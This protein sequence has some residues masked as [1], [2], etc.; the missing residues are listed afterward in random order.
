MTEIIRTYICNKKFTVFESS[1]NKGISYEEE[2]IEARIVPVGCDIG[3]MRVFVDIISED[4]VRSPLALF[5]CVDDPKLEWSRRI[6]TNSYGDFTGREDLIT[7]T[8]PHLSYPCKRVYTAVHN[9][10]MLSANLL[11]LNYPLTID[12]GLVPEEGGKREAFKGTTTAEI[13]NTQTQFVPGDLLQLKWGAKVDDE[14]YESFVA[15]RFFSTPAVT[16]GRVLG[17]IGA[18]ITKQFFVK[19][20]RHVLRCTPTD[21]ADYA[22]DDWIYLIK[23]ANNDAGNVDRRQSYTDNSAEIN[24]T[25]TSLR[26]FPATV[27]NIGN[28]STSFEKHDYDMLSVGA[29]EQFFEMSKHIAV[30][31]SIDYANDTADVVFNEDTGLSGEYNGVS[32]YYL[33][34]DSNTFED[35]SK[36]FA[37]G[38]EVLVLNEYGTGD[39]QVSNLKIVGHKEGLKNCVDSFLLLVSTPSGDEATVW[40]IETDS[41]FIEKGTRSQVLSQLG[42]GGRSL[43]PELTPTEEEISYVPIDD[44]EYPDNRE[45]EWTLLPSLF[46]SPDFYCHPDIFFSDPYDYDD[47]DIIPPP[48]FRLTTS[49]VED[50]VYD[51]DDILW[52]INEVQYTSAVVKDPENDESKEHYGTEQKTSQANGTQTVL[53]LHH[54]F[55]PPVPTDWTRPQFTPS[56]EYL[57]DLHLFTQQY[58]NKLFS[59][60]TYK[61][62]QYFGIA[63][64]GAG[65]AIYEH[66]TLCDSFDTEEDSCSGEFSRTLR[67]FTRHRTPIHGSFAQEVMELINFERENRSIAPIK[68]NPHLYSATETHATDMSDNAFVGH[69]GTD[70]S[71]PKDRIE[72]TDYLLHNTIGF[73]TDVSGETITTVTGLYGENCAGVKDVYYDTVSEAIDA[74]ISGEAIFESGT[75]S[76]SRIDTNIYENVLS[77]NEYS[78]LGPAERTV[79]L[80]MASTEG[81]REI[82]LYDGSYNLWDGTHAQAPQSADLSADQ[83]SLAEK[84][85]FGMSMTLG[86]DNYYYAALNVGYRPHFLQGFAAMKTENLVTYIEDN[87]VFDSENT[88]EKLKFELV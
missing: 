28:E 23:Q 65:D 34:Q 35:G 7:I 82:L 81:H 20:Q 26:P 53:T 80:W 69:Q 59:D 49:V 29:F 63:S 41:V 17:S 42:S 12:D 51:A 72:N 16:G 57:S 40:D 14:I 31:N 37:E 58:V 64:N 85:D 88:Y 27:N 79:G 77:Q 62:G 13:R 11:F 87:F 4:A 36:G 68:W 76:A 73:V 25:D 45:S 21:F 50:G 44:T 46:T 24:G 60:Y 19:T 83:Y 71:W 10:R 61:M 38:D 66:I 3:L 54:L 9:I 18:G 67:L 70:D 33:C 6:T 43:G 48:K 74:A 56:G 15:G 84:L 52:K 30:V 32:I 78:L 55:D 1:E 22:T 5:R 86:S 47:V 2:Y 8:V 75:T 39:P